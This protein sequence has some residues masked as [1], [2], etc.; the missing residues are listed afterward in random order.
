MTSLIFAS[1]TLCRSIT[2]WFDKDGSLV[3]ENFFRFF[4]E[5]HYEVKE[6]KVL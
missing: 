5:L 1:L 3:M 4:D 2:K 6:K